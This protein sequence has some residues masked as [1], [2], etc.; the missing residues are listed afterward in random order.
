MPFR[1]PITAAATWCRPRRDGQSFCTSQG[2][3]A[4]TWQS[5]SAIGPSI[6]SMISVTLTWCG[7]RTSP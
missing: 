6:A 4:A 5:V 2:L 1:A 7:S 3:P